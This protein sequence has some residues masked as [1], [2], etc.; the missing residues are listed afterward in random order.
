MSESAVLP[1]ER[2]AADPAALVGAE[3]H[4]AQGLVAIRQLAEAAQAHGAAQA[5][6][7]QAG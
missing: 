2:A 6:A 7:A 5:Q 1:A 4:A 3:T